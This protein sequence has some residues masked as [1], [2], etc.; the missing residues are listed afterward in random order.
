MEAGGVAIGAVAM[1]APAVQA[2][3]GAYGVYQGSTEYGRDYQ[4][5]LR[6]IMAQRLILEGLMRLRI[7][8]LLLEDPKGG[9]PLM[10][11]ILGEL[12]T[13]RNNF[14]TCSKLINK[15]AIKSDRS[16]ADG[17]SSSIKM[18]PSYKIDR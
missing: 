7:E 10:K 13:M 16:S 6:K 14:E 9:E 17:R 5:A 2:C 4:L 15:L 18:L 3:W 1:L 8:D 11:T 12:V